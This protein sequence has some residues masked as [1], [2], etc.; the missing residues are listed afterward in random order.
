MTDIYNSEKAASEKLEKQ[1]PEP[2]IP[3][4]TKVFIE[5]KQKTI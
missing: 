3:L 4:M 1:G 5:G 2:P